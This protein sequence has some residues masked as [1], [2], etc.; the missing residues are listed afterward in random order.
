MRTLPAPSPSIPGADS[1]KAFLG[2]EVFEAWVADF[3]RRI[4]HVVDRIGYGLGHIEET[5]RQSALAL[6]CQLVEKAMQAKADTIP[7][8]CDKCLGPLVDTRVAK[9]R[10]IDIYCGKAT[11]TR[12]YGFCGPCQKWSFPADFA[13]GLLENSNASPLVQEMS[14]LL[15]AKMPA[16]Q[17][18]EII[19]R[20]AGVSRSRSTMAREALRQGERGTEIISHLLED[21][22]RG[23]LPKMATP[24]PTGGTVV[25]QID[26]LN[27][28]ERDD[29][30]ET[31]AMRA[32]G[33]PL[34]RWHWIYAATCFRLEQRCTTGGK[35]RAVITDKSV[36]ATRKGID[37]L[38]RELHF[39]AQLRGVASAERVLVL[40]DGAVWI[41]NAAKDR[42]PGAI[43]RL[44]LW[45][46]NAYLWA[47]AN[48]LHGKDTAKARE[49]VKPLLKQVREDQTLQ[50]ITELEELKK[51]LT[52]AQSQAVVD[53]TVVYYKNNEP[54]M[55][56]VD[57][58]KRNEPK[59]SGAIESVCRQLQ[60]RVKRCGQFWSIVGDE[61]ILRLET[62][63]RNGH[64][65]RLFPHCEL[66]FAE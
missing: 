2:A 19:A 58:E 25:V 6:Q 45:H 40:A 49:W 37:A 15:V 11:L 21:A 14:A 20:V 8:L 34:D 30:G 50:V 17:A 9:P 44:D 36:I 63:W 42:F 52:E 51:T 41:W 10:T 28:R 29:W 23:I 56:Y 66:Q 54:R 27:V 32:A 62:L 3:E 22:G 59:G 57:A 13:L 64:W 39:E 53:K 47:V 5:V 1:I 46:G 60:C 65:T 48:E 43:E 38:M 33:K 26:A 16:A 55:K 61:A 12:R 24:P 18:E 31:E 35:Q 7:A 4:S